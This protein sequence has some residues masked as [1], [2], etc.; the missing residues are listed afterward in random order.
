MKTLNDFHKAREMAVAFTR[1][2]ADSSSLKLVKYISIDTRRNTPPE[3]YSEFTTALTMAGIT[4]NTIPDSVYIFAVAR[5]SKTEIHVKYCLPLPEGIDPAE[6]NYIIQTKFVRD[7]RTFQEAKQK[8]ADFF[9]NEVSQ[10]TTDEIKTFIV[11]K[12]PDME[13]KAVSEYST[14]L[15]LAGITDEADQGTGYIF[16]LIANGTKYIQ[17]EYM[18]PNRSDAPAWA[19]MSRIFANVR[20]LGKLIRSRSLNQPKKTL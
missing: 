20:G 16:H 3:I 9:I 10:S 7:L 1:Q 14:A 4:L 6:A 18:N 15:K 5:H 11:L 19:T 13:P 12:Y 17:I 8:A 2:M